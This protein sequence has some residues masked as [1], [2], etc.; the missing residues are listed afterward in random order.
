[1]G[2]RPRRWRRSARIGRAGFGIRSRPLRL[3]GYDAQHAKLDRMARRGSSDAGRGGLDLRSCRA[4]G[5]TPHAGENGLSMERHDEHLSAKGRR[6]IRRKT[7]PVRFTKL[8]P[9]R[10]QA[11]RKLRK[12]LSTLD[13]NIIWLPCGSSASS[14]ALNECCRLR[15]RTYSPKTAAGG[16]VA[17]A[18][19]MHTPAKIPGI[20]E[21][22]RPGQEYAAVCPKTGGTQVAQ[23][24]SNWKC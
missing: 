6:S 3:A 23:F 16:S 4:M 19:Q 8:V 5:H 10:A 18:A 21:P 9:V 24:Q 15:L 17:S 13:A 7:A 12:F 20:T 1:V 11:G 14:V 2:E 22:Q